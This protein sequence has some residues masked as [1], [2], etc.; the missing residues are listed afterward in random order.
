[1]LTA[2]EGRL[3]IRRQRFAHPANC[4]ATPRIAARD[5]SRVPRRRCRRSPQRQNRRIRRSFKPALTIRAGRFGNTGHGRAVRAHLAHAAPRPGGTARSTRLGVRCTRGATFRQ[6]CEPSP[7]IGSE[8]VQSWRHTGHPTDAAGWGFVGFVGAVLAGDPNIR[9]AH[10]T[11][12]A[13]L[14]CAQ[15]CAHSLHRSVSRRC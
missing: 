2:R 14:D 7:F 9:L 12:I 15:F 11:R 13:R 10:D 4:R 1:M 3:S 5:R 8:M 6:C